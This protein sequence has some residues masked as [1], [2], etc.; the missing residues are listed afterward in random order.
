MSG[1]TEY[2]RQRLGLA[3]MISGPCPAPVLREVAETLCDSQ[4]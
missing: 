4:R 1:L 2:Q 3:G